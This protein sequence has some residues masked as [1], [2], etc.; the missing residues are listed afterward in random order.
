MW[1]KALGAKEN[2]MKHHRHTTEFKVQALELAKQLGSYKKAADQLGIKDSTIHVWKKKF[3][4]TIDDKKPVVS[5]VAETEEVRNLKKKIQDLEKTN[6]ILKRAAA[7][8]SQDH[9]K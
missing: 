9:L 5:A 8:F 3:N 4:I 2:H 1:Y 6:Y 7:F